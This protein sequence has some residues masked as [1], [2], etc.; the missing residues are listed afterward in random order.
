MRHQGTCH[1]FY[2]KLYKTMNSEISNNINLNNFIQ[3]NKK[4]LQ[5]INTL[6][7]KNIKYICKEHN[8]NF[9]K[10]CLTCKEDICLQCNNNSHFIHDTVKYQDISLND[11]QI[12]LFKKEYN[13]YIE[14]FCDL[15]LK[16][17][18]WKINLNNAIIELEEYMK[19]N[20]IEIIN[21][22]INDYN[23][24]EINYNTI[25][26][27]RLIYSLSHFVILSLS[28]IMIT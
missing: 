10:Y 19:K 6:N 26:E 18:Q 8:R 15:F 9:Y 16:I 1:N 22:M 17:K 13:E 3:Q 27:Y 14:I 11:K 28:I 20:V 21:K 12:N 4:S 25:I 7:T 24:N 23:I 5:K 2:T